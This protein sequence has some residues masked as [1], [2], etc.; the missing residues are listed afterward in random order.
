MVGQDLHP[1]KQSR[2]CSIPLRFL[3][4]NLILLGVKGCLQSLLIV[5]VAVALWNLNQVTSTIV[6]ESCRIQMVTHSERV[7]SNQVESRPS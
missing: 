5:W 6:R 1:T 4:L 2:I 7:G 3:V